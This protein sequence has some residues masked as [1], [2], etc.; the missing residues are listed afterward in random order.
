MRRSAIRLV[1]L[2]AKERS[3]RVTSFFLHVHF[4]LFPLE[5]GGE[6]ETR[7]R[8]CVTYVCGG[9]MACAGERKDTAHSP[10]PHLKTRRCS[11]LA[12]LFVQRRN[13]TFLSSNANK[14]SLQIVFLFR[15]DAMR[16]RKHSNQSRKRK[17]LHVYTAT[18]GIY[19]RT[20]SLRA[21]QTEKNM[22]TRDKRSCTCI[23]IF[24]ASESSAR[25]AFKNRFKCQSTAYSTAGHSGRSKS[26]R[27]FVACICV[28]VS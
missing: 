22:Y 23:Q 8:Q 6:R 17:Y 27:S 10:L 7:L 20:L 28:E 19:N 26:V 21:E 25:K 15:K 24:S 16:G 18:E 5:G 3:L 12:A 4:S 1:A 9:E 11:L 13:E 2:Y 14:K